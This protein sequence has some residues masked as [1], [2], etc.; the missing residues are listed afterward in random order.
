MCKLIGH[1]LKLIPLMEMI[2]QLPIIKYQ[3][4]FFNNQ[5]SGTIPIAYQTMGNGLGLLLP[6]LKI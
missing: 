3:F 2:M 1:T 5:K 6:R 4:I